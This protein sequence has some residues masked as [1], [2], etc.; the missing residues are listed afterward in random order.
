MVN[1]DFSTI[2]VN[3]HSWTAG[4]IVDPELFGDNLA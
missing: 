2:Y 1:V 4:D 3:G